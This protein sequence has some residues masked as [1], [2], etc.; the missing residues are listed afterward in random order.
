MC[1][2]KKTTAQQSIVAELYGFILQQDARQ[3]NEASRAI[4]MSKQH[5]DCPTGKNMDC[6]LSSIS[7]VLRSTVLTVV[8][9]ERTGKK[10]S[11]LRTWS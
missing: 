8:S 10:T 9:F 11:Q 4:S 2:N 7:V 6:V 1:C 5:T 3:R